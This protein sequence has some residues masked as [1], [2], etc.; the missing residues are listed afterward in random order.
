MLSLPSLS[1]SHLAQPASHVGWLPTT[2][3]ATSET[4]AASTA[5]L[6]L[7]SRAKFTLTPGPTLFLIPSAE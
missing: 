7:L 3:I 5:A 4:L 1:G 2:T 6:F